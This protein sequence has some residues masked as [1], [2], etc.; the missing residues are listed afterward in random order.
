[1]RNSCNHAAVGVLAELTLLYHFRFMTACPLN[2]KLEV[3]YATGSAPTD[4][5]KGDES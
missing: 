2:P 4:P 3:T 1:M 5:T